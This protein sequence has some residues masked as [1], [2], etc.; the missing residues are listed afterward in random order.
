[1]T[2]SPPLASRLIYAIGGG[3]CALAFLGLTLYALV[4]TP[5]WFV[6]AALT[7]LAGVAMSGVFVLLAYRGGNGT[8]LRADDATVGQYPPIGPPRIFPR[9]QLGSI[10]G[11]QGW[12]GLVQYQFVARDGA[13]LMQTGASFRRSDLERFAQFVGVP[14]RWSALN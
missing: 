14:F 13:L 1:M 9:Q 2:I 11:V 4:S 8:Q 6:R 3:A 12:R 7:T 5:F 10:A